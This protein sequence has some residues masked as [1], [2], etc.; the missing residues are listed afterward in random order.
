MVSVDYSQF[1]NF[2]KSSG[3]LNELKIKC[4]PVYVQVQHKLP[5]FTTLYYCL[6]NYTPSKNNPPQNTFAVIKRHVQETT[7]ICNPIYESNWQLKE[8]ISGAAK[9]QILS[10]V[11]KNGTRAP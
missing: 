7:S 4:P 5:C 1:L 9:S 3:R 11:T 6:K 8:L 2:K 10:K